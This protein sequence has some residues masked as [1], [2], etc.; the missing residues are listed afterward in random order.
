MSKKTKKKLHVTYNKKRFLAPDS[1]LSMA[2]IHTKIKPC[3]EAQ[4]RISDCNRTIK[5]WNDLNE[6]KEIEEMI[7]KTENLINHL[8]EFKKELIIKRGY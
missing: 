8:I 4:I 1:L 3:G 6:R 7:L 2:V 5:I